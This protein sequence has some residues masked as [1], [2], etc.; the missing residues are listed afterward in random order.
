MERDNV[1]LGAPKLN[2]DFSL[3]SVKMKFKPVD[4]EI[5]IL[6]MGMNQ[7]K[8]TLKKGR[9]F[10]G[11]ALPD[12][13]QTMALPLNPH[14]FVM[15]TDQLV[16]NDDATHKR[17]GIFTST[18]NIHDPDYNIALKMAYDKLVDTF[19]EHNVLNPFGPRQNDP[20]PAVSAL[21]ADVA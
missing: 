8:I 4:F 5:G 11:K 21:K 6:P 10:L 2:I 15:P 16:A 19:G 3:Q 17:D 18:V 9:E 12:V 14:H 20:A 7:V 1:G 13:E